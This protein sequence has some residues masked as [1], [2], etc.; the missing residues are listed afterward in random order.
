MQ[1]YESERYLPKKTKTT[2]NFTSGRFTLFVHRIF[3]AI[4]DNM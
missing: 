1:M 3:H 4:G 2:T